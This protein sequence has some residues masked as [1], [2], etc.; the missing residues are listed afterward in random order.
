MKL[1]VIVPVYN[2]E[3]YIVEC[4]E[5]LIN[6]TYTDIEIVLVDDGSTDSSGKICDE[7]A[8]KYERVVTLHKTN[9]GLMSAWKY[10]VKHAKGEIIGFVDSDDWVDSN[11]Y[12][13]LMS[14]LIKSDSDIV[15]CGLI[16]GEYL[17]HQSGD[18]DGCYYVKDL[19][20]TIVNNGKFLGRGII[21]SRVVKIFKRD[22][23]NK[24][25]PYCEDSISLGEDMVMNFA[26]F[27]FAER[28]SFIHNFFP[29]HYRINPT[30][31]TQSFKPRLFE[32]ALLFNNALATIANSES[33][34][35]FQSQI[36]ADLACNIINII[37]AAFNSDATVKQLRA[38]LITVI[39]N[40]QSFFVIESVDTSM[41]SMRY[42]IYHSL[43]KQKK[44][45]SIL[46][47]GLVVR[48]IRNTHKM[49]KK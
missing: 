32:Q 42:K 1:S 23:V 22:I 40:N 5:S 7:Y 15:V 14:M 45:N 20:S 49:I 44:I 36:E 10:G 30:S 38:F 31:I 2:V 48:F 33:K 3:K 21:P 11:M 4:V 28:V 9:G 46:L 17:Q 18:Y 43:L 35:D 6:Q 12:E 19:Y 26:S 37:E 16:K 27:M 29:Y 24:A 25:I 39:D 13:S 34:F 47:Y 8:L 41:W